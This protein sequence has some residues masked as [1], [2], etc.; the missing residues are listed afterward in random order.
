MHQTILKKV[1]GDS[2]SALERFVENNTHLEKNQKAVALQTLQVVAAR[3]NQPGAVRATRCFVVLSKKDATTKWIAAANGDPELSMALRVCKQINPLKDIGV[4][5]Q[6][7]PAPQS[8][9]PRDVGSLAFGQGSS[10][11]R[12]QKPTKK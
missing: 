1:G 6:T 7:D 2:T 3:A 12:K 10:S 8:Q 9:A 4:E 5:S 11:Q